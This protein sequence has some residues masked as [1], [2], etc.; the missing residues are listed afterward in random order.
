MRLPVMVASDILNHGTV[1]SSGHG[2]VQSLKKKIQFILYYLFV[3]QGMSLE[4][5]SYKLMPYVMRLAEAVTGYQEK[6][7]FMQ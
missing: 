1:E 4:W 2:Y 5:Q 3:F 7:R 6:V